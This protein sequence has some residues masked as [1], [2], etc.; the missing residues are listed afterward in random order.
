MIERLNEETLKR[1]YVREGKSTRTIAKMF[2]CSYFGILYRCKKYEIK[3]R[4]T[5]KRII[6]LDKP[7][8][9]RL[10]V[11]EGKSSKEVAEMFSCS[12]QTVLKRCKEYGISLKGRKIKGLTKAL[13]HRLYIKEGKTTREIGKIVGCSFDVVRKRC[14]QF[15]IPLR[16]PGCKK[17]EIDESALRR[18]YV[19]EGKSMTKIAEFFD[20][21]IS[22][23]YKRAKRIGL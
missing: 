22:T 16:N 11:K 21:S 8:L 9:K 10:C 5:R 17:I 19:K 2:D 13:L 12:S 20:C 23:I 1:L 6:K 14:K 18:L 3:L 7:V 4:P 15:G